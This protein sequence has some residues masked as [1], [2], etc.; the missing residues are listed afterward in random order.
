[1]VLQE[2]LDNRH[3]KWM[4]CSRKLHVPAKKNYLVAKIELQNPQAKLNWGG[5]PSN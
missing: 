1:M 3:I 5:C 4:K 2:K